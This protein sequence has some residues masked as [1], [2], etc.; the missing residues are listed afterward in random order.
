MELLLDRCGHVAHPATKP[1][2]TIKRIMR[3]AFIIV[4]D[5]PTESAVALFRRSTR[6]LQQIQ[7]ESRQLAAT[8]AR[9]ES[10]S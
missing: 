9:L 3:N 7:T 10:A 1:K 6:C 4:S 5:R 8:M 2:T